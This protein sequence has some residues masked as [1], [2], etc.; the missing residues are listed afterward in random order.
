MTQAEVVE[1]NP[2]PTQASEEVE[3]AQEPSLDSLLSEYEEP[4]EEPKQAPQPVAPISPDIQNFMARQIKKDNDQAISEAAESIR[5]AVG[6]TSLPTKWFEGQLHLAGAKDPRLT[7]AFQNRESNPAKWNNIVKALGQELKSD[8]TPVD[9]AAT[10]SWNAVEASVRS[11][12]TSAPKQASE[13]DAKALK[14]MSDQEF[15][16][17]RK[18]MGYKR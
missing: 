4:K 17:Y 3:G 2:E 12:S 9:T 1:T 16:A 5:E 7:E 13:I 18:E 15:E 14:N 10:D 6:E 11:A 8:L